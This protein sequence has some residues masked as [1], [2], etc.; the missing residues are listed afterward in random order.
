LC[1]LY[2]VPAVL[3]WDYLR[4]S[5]A[6]SGQEQRPSGLFL[7]PGRSARIALAGA[8]LL[9][10]VSVAAAAQQRSDASVR[11]LVASHRGSIRAAADQYDVDPRLIASLVYVTHRDQLTPFRDAL[12][13]VVTSAWAMNLREVVGIGP[14]DRVNTAETDE[15]PLL[16][17]VLDV[18]VGLAQIKP[19]TAQTASV[20]AMG[21]TPDELPR[22]TADAY[23]DV[24]PVGRNWRRPGGDRTAIAAPIPVPAFRRQVAAVLLDD[25]SNLA[26][27]ALILALYQRQWESAN[28]DWSLRERPEILATLYQIGFARS[29]PHAAP[30]S[31]AFGN[32]VREVFGQRW[33]EELLERPGSS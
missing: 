4:A 8:A 11:Q 32:R 9:A 10:L 18:S 22:P 25:R 24:E 33:L 16:N 27:C 7:L 30:R 15:N 17:R 31:N 6:P 12:E 5:S 2:L 26:M 29:R 28:Q 23:K 19:R 14:P 20:L 13:R 1:P 21:L 3:L